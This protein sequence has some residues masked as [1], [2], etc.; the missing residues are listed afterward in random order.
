[1]KPKTECSTLG[2]LERLAAHKVNNALRGVIRNSKDLWT[3]PLKAARSQKCLTFATP[4]Q[5]NASSLLLF[6]GFKPFTDY[7]EA[8][9][10]VHGGGY[11][12]SPKPKVEATP[13]YTQYVLLLV[14]NSAGK[15]WTKAV[16]IKKQEILTLYDGFELKPITLLL[17]LEAAEVSVKDTEW[18]TKHVWV[19]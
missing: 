19:H 12:Q 15:T 7:H 8:W 13:P 2:P 3:K 5:P 1:M 16:D 4:Y 9:I 17:Q 11:D 18:N 10:K 6:I 14:T